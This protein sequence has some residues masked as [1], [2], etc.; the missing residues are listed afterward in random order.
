MKSAEEYAEGSAR[1]VSIPKERQD[2]LGARR[3]TIRAFEAYSRFV[4]STYCP[5]R[6]TGQEH[7]PKSSF[8]LCSNHCSHMDSTVLMTASGRAFE[9]FGLI[10]AR[11][12][13]VAGGKW[14]AAL[15]LLVNVLPVDR[16]GTRKAIAEHIEQCRTFLA[17]GPRALIMYPEGTRTLTGEMG[18]FKKGVGMLAVELGVPVVP[19]YIDGTFQRWRKGTR[20]IKPGPIRVAIGPA[21][22]PHDAAA[23]GGSAQSQSARRYGPVT[24]ELE[25]RVRRLREELRDGRQ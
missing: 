15:K 10:A 9:E 1:A 5:L 8:L 24:Q 18:P 17:Q 25:S 6:V 2:E 20:F 4:L 16:R 22:F 12:Y 11:D 21:V 14:K 7:L 3:V 19:A 23:G 13:F